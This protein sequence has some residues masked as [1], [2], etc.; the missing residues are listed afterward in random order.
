M[1]TFAYYGY[2]AVP[3]VSDLVE[4]VE[5]EVFYGNWDYNR[6]WIENLLIGSSA[7]DAG[8]G[9]TPEVLR[10][11]L[12]MGVITATKKWVHWD[13]G[14]VDGSEVLRGILWHSIAVT[15]LAGGQQDKYMGYIA[16]GG[17]V[18]AKGILVPGSTDIGLVGDP[19]EAAVRTA[20]DAGDFH[21]DDRHYQ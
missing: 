17:F 16:T 6:S 21:L 13:D 8:N 15:D 19:K 9:S 1:T 14:A 10:P 18:K 5:N 11:G 3:G 4:T 7:R 2:G 12:L 20:M